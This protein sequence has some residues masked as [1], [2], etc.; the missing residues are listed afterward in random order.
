MLISLEKTQLKSKLDFTFV[1]FLYKLNCLDFFF[2][3]FFFELMSIFFL[4]FLF[5]YFVCEDIECNKL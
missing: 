1:F 4:L 2:C 5:E 3:Y